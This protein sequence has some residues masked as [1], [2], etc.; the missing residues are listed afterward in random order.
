MRPANI[1]KK[2]GNITLLIKEMENYTYPKITTIIALRAITDFGLKDAKDFVEY[3]M[4]SKRPVII[5]KNMSYKQFKKILYDFKMVIGE[6]SEGSTD[7]ELP[8]HAKLEFGRRDGIIFTSIKQ[9][10]KYPTPVIISED[11]YSYATY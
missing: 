4:Q 6:R 3:C 1:R 11:T 7:L 9:K 10:I 8:K 5:S 2:N